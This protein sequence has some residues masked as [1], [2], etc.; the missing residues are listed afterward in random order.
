MTTYY[1]RVWTC[2]IGRR[3]NRPLP[4]GGAD[5]TMRQAVEAAYREVTGEE[6]D[7]IFSGWSGGLTFAEEE[8]LGVLETGVDSVNEESTK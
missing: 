6:P 8:V 5:V 1:K 4:V 3:D 7:F 2:T